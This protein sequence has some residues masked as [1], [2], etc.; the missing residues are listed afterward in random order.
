MGMLNHSLVIIHDGSYIKDISLTVSS[1][2]TIIN[3]TVAK[4]WCKCTWAEQSEAVRSYC[5]E[6][7][8]GIMT[9]LILKAA[10]TGYNKKIPH[11]GVDCDNDGMSP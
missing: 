8:G 11:I 1:A 6:I 4:A 2:A 9:Q 7:L 5:G 10:A 3:C